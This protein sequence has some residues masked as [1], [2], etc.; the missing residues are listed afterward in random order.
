MEIQ[1]GKLWERVDIVSFSF[2]MSGK[3]KG[4]CSLV[5]GKK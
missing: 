4:N 1:I 5:K 2:D 3:N